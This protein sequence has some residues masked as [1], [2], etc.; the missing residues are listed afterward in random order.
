MNRF[1]HPWYIE[2]RQS[3][4]HPWKPLNAYRTLDEATAAWNSMHGG[5]HKHLYRVRAA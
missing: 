5:K 3:A 1:T 4:F 2:M